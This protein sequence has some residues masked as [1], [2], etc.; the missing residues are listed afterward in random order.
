MWD[1]S[2]VIGICIIIGAICLAVG[3]I[4]GTLV[5]DSQGRKHR[6]RQAYTLGYGEFT[7]EGHS[8]RFKWTNKNK[9]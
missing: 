7:V 6:E 1:K 8:V 2:D 3:F 9:Q 5:G 4:T